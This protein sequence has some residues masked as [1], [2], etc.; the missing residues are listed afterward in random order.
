MNLRENDW[1]NCERIFLSV[2]HMEGEELY[3]LAIAQFC[4][5]SKHVRVVYFWAERKRQE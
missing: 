5:L 4:C 1:V 2:P 3:M